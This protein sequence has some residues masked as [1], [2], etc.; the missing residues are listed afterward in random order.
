MRAK[1]EL[2]KSMRYRWVG[3]DYTPWSGGPGVK[4]F[5]VSASF[6]AP[7]DRKTGSYLLIVKKCTVRFFTTL[8]GHTP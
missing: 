1:V 6:S 8:L 3:A 7:G 5:T 2:L 4:F